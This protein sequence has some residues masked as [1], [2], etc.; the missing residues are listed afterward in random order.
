MT[1]FQFGKFKDKTPDA[2]LKESGGEQYLKWL[3]DPATKFNFSGDKGKELKNAIY[4]ALRIEIK[5]S[6]A[7]KQVSVK[8]IMER[9]TDSIRTIK[10]LNGLF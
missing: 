3:I 6:V 1:K 2:V 10:D 9:H 7:P 5:P 8:E 4:T